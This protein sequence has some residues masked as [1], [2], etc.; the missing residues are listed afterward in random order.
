VQQ[1]ALDT[2]KKD[3]SLVDPIAVLKYLPGGK[4]PKCPY[5][6]SYVLGK[7]VSDAP[8]CTLPEHSPDYQHVQ[9]AD[10]MG[11]PLGGVWVTVENH[12]EMTD[13]T[14]GVALAITNYKMSAKAI[15]VSKE[16][17]ETKRIEL[18]VS[19]PLKVALTRRTNNSTEAK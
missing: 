16:G 1:W 11:K 8:H 18:P 10:E 15:V 6:G 2:G 5:G 19:W 4:M 17:Y 12:Q 7:T 3:D 14:T 13:S 9:V